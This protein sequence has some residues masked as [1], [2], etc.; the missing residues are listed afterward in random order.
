VWTEDEARRFLKTV[1]EGE[2][3]QDAALFAL[4]L[5]GGLRRGELRGLLWKDLNGSSLRVERQLF[6]A[7]ETAKGVFALDTTP[8]K[9]KC[10]RTI[11]LSDETL[12]LLREHKRQQAELKLKNRL[13]YVDLGLMFAQGWE[14]QGSKNARLGLPLSRTWLIHRLRRACKASGVKRI[15]PHGLR[16]TCTT[17]LMLAD[18]PVVVV[19]KRLGHASPAMTLNIY[20]HALPSMQKDAASR[21]QRVLHE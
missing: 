17:L 4:A 11:D 20:S 9:G 16:H 1:K 13:Q 19:A 6:D 14:E 15:S 7:V 21:L 18:V 2:N 8:P 3:R 12:S 5:D 10:A